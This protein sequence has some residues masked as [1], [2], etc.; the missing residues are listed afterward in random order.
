MK[1]IVVAVLGACGWMGRVHSNAYAG[2]AR[3]FPELGAEVVVK[4]LVDEN[5][6]GARQAARLPGIVELVADGDF[7]AAGES[8]DVVG[9]GGTLLMS[10]GPGGIDCAPVLGA[11]VIPEATL[12]DWAADGRA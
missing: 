6:A 8:V 1:P 7:D 11:I 9:E 5:E 3:Q 12:A 10:A 4:W 2:M